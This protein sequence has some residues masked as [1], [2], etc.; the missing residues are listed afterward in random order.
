[1]TTDRQGDGT[2]ADTS[3]YPAPNDQD[4]IRGLLADDEHTLGNVIR[5]YGKGVYG[6]AL[7]IL[8]ESGHAEEVAQDTF[9]ALWLNPGR[10]DAS[11]GNLRSFLIG[12]ARYKAIDLVR[13]EE[14]IRSKESL[15]TEFLEWTE[16][17]LPQRVHD[18][19]FLRGALSELPRLK[20]EV[21]FLAYYR[22]LTSQQIAKHLGIP[23]GTAKTRIRDALIKLRIS[24]AGSR[25][26]GEN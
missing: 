11:K 9:L 2:P 6:S 1:M 19:L 15:A 3:S 20:L 10:F 17:P 12:T 22:G 26:V 14:V 18:E 8:R 23:E 21:I 13:R 24:L 16:P 4:A 5:S 25:T 7:R